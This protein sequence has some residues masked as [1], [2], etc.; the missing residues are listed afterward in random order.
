VTTGYGVPGG[1]CGG[2]HKAYDYAANTGHDVVAAVP[3]VVTGLS[4]GSS[5][6]TQIVIDNDR[7]PDGSPGLW[8][9]YAHLSKKSVSVGQRVSAGQKI[10]EVGNTGNSTG[11]HLHFEV[12]GQDYWV[13]GGGKNPQKW[14]SFNAGSGG[15]DPYPTPSGKV[16]YLDKLRYGQDDSDSVWHLQDV[17]NGHPL[18][19]GQTLPTTA[20]Y[21]EMTDHEVRLCQQQHGFGND[22]NNQSYVGPQQAEHLFGGKGYDIRS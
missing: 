8:A 4:W 21:G 11:P 18:N 19:G 7:F 14:T 9:L 15:T 13:C 6:G 17:L 12:Q 1:W 5:F 3:G 20:Y 2:S 10:G 16:V 22:P